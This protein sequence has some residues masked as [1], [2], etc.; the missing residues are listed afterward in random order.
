MSE[1]IS[2]I[3]AETAG[4]GNRQKKEIPGMQKHYWPILEGIGQ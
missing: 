1:K 3:V 2:G 4:N